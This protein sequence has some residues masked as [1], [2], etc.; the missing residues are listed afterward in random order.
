MKFITVHLK[1]ND[2]KFA[3]NPMMITAVKPLKEGGSRIYYTLLSQHD[4]ITEEYDSILIK[5]NDIL[6]GWL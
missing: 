4:D 1:L 3:V 6:E 5:I 2:Q